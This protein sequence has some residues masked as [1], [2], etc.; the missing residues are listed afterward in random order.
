MIAVIIAIA[1]VGTVTSEKDK[2]DT[3]VSDGVKKEQ[4]HKRLAGLED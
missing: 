4:E 1:F 2:K 3:N